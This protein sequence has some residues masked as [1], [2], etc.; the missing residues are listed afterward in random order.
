MFAGAHG[1]RYDYEMV[2]RIAILGWGSL[3]WDSKGD[4]DEWHGPWYND[5]P[6]L[7]LEFSR[8]SRTR[9]GALTLVIDTAHGAATTVTYCLSKRCK[10]GDVVDDLRRRE[11]TTVKNIGCVQLGGE[12]RSR[13]GR[14]TEEIAGW[15]THKGLNAVVWTDLPSNFGKETGR[16]FTVE[17]A[18][19]HLRGLKWPAEAAAIDYIRRAPEFVRT[20]VRKALAE[21]GWNS[22]MGKG[23]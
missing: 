14:I 6:T 11:G 16:E 17:N 21:P 9:G 20:P 12:M 10:I 8:V 22:K 4:F 23:G 5:G 13:D 7:R 1:A 18:L 3:L 15:A 19:A 2:D